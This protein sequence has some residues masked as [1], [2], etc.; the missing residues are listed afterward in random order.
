MRIEAG[1]I[2]RQGKA[3]TNFDCTLPAAQSG[4]ARESLK[5]PCKLD[6]PGLQEDAR[7][8]EIEQAL[9]NHVAEFLLELGAGFAYVGRQ[10]HLAA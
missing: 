1:A 8:R 5:D 9:V 2:E 7:E 6:F 4:L 10:V 3:V